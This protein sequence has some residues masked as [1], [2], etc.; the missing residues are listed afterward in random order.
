MSPATCTLLQIMYDRQRELP[1][2][3]ALRTLICHTLFFVMQK[4]LSKKRMCQT[5]VLTGPQHPQLTNSTLL[6]KLAY[7]SC[8]M[9]G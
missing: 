3:L 1:Y 8:V 5:Q 2:V 6:S 7:M 9:N 4:N